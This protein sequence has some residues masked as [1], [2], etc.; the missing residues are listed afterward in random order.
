[1]GLRIAD[2]DT[3]D[4]MKQSSNPTIKQSNNQT[5]QNEPTDKRQLPSSARPTEADGNGLH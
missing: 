1:M 2:S 3:A 5:I 4:S